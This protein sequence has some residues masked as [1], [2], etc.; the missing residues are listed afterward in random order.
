MIY[1]TNKKTWGSAKWWWCVGT[2]APFA[3]IYIVEGLHVVEHVVDGLHVVE[4]VVEG[5]HVVEQVVEGLQVR[6]TTQKLKLNL[7]SFH[8][9]ELLAFSHVPQNMLN[10]FFSAVIE[11]NIFKLYLQKCA[12]KCYP[13]SVSSLGIG[14][15]SLKMLVYLLDYFF[16]YWQHSSK[17]VLFVLSK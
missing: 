6:A 1:P 16:Q 9:L 11:I 13:F 15:L 5:L 7:N 4:L 10:I 8:I 14:N 3:K 17:P 12:C 2:T